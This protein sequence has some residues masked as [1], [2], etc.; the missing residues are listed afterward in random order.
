MSNEDYIV[1]LNLGLQGQIVWIQILAMPF[2]FS[3]TLMQLLNLSVSQDLGRL[4]LSGSP[5]IPSAK[6]PYRF[7]LNSK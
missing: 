7:T 5:N 3:E 1:A 4:N 6:Q 2:I